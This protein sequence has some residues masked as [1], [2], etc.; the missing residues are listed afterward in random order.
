MTLALWPTTHAGMSQA[1]S[2]ASTD[3]IEADFKAASA[4]LAEAQVG[5]CAQW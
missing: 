1:V 2:N 4:R 3:G 5:M